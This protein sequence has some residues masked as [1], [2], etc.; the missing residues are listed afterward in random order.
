MGNDDES[1]YSPHPSTLFGM[2]PVHLGR[3]DLSLRY[4]D[5][6]GVIITQAI[7]TVTLWF[8]YTFEHASSVDEYD[9]D[10]ELAAQATAEGQV[11]PTSV[12][13]V[14]VQKGKL[15]TST[16]CHGWVS[17]MTT[18]CA[19]EGFKRERTKA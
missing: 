17:R 10:Q 4:G 13:L 18:G 7:G 19:G 3:S 12:G 9:S 1:F 16:D 14:C 15:L 6:Q 8:S 5:K 11:P 2:I